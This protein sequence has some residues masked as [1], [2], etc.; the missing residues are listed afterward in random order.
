MKNYTKIE[1][2]NYE[3]KTVTYYHLGGMNYFTS[4]VEPRGYYLSVTPVQVDRRADGI[5]VESFSAF[6]GIKQLLIECKRKSVKTE[7][8]AEK[9]AISKMFDLETYV[10]N[11]LKSK[12]K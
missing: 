8:Q 12:I 11:Q 4:R 5:V 2:T 6:S 10:I 9:I 1:G 7:E 3:L